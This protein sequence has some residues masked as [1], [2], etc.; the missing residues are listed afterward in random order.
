VNFLDLFYDDRKQLLFLL[1]YITNKKTTE[2]IYKV[3][4]VSLKTN[5]TIR[6]DTYQSQSE[7]GIAGD[8]NLIPIVKNDSTFQ[9]LSDLTH[10]ILYEK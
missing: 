3:T 1:G 5:K 2:N 9:V 4:K 10:E 7:I 6:S 8:G